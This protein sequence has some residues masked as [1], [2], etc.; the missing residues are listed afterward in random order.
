MCVGRARATEQKSRMKE[1]P[2]GRNKCRGA[3]KSKPHHGVEAHFEKA[4]SDDT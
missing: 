1:A 4:T 3:G 2:S